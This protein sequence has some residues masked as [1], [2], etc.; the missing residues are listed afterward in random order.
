MD[1]HLNNT[2]PVF[3]RLVVPLVRQLQQYRMGNYR[4]SNPTEGIFATFHTSITATIPRCKSLT[5]EKFVV[6]SICILE[7]RTA[8]KNT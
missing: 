6:I 8:V 7:I 1:R 3:F 4:E 5:L 2:D